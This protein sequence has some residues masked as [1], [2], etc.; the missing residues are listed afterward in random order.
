MPEKPKR[1]RSERRDGEV[2]TVRKV[3]NRRKRL[4]VEQPA[5]PFLRGPVPWHW[6][7]EAANLPG[8]ALHVGLALH[9]LSGVRKAVKVPLTTRVLGELGVS[10]QRARDALARLEGAGLVRVERQPGRIH[11]IEIL[12]RPPE[13]GV[14]AENSEEQRESALAT[15][16]PEPPAEVY[17]A[18]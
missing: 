8:K 5:D 11:Q 7:C 17:R 1:P 15:A 16:S 2:P 18:R 6:L 9:F 3:Y 10:R 12:S 13:P 14:S 4:F